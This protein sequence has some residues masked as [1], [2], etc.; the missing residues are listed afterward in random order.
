M[1]MSTNTSAKILLFCIIIFSPDFSQ[2]FGRN[3]RDNCCEK[4][5]TKF[6]E[7]Y[8]IFAFRENEKTVFVSTLVEG[9]IFVCKKLA[10]SCENNEIFAKNFNF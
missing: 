9:K 10:K 5:Q 4:S 6:C 8:L 7:N 3:F 1:K 2:F